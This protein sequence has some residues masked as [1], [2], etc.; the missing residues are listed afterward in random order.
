MIN[1]KAVDNKIEVLVTD[2][3]TFVSDK[4]SLTSLDK[5]VGQPTWAH[6]ELK[7]SG[8][9]FQNLTNVFIKICGENFIGKKSQHVERG[10]RVSQG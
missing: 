4:L 9:V 2:L 7:S 6:D 1:T 10:R 3:N 5:M 8:G